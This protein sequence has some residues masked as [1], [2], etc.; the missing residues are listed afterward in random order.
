MREQSAR[1]GLC[2]RT[3]R[4]NGHDAVLGFEHIARARDDQRRVQVPHRQHRFQPAQHAVRTPVLGELHGRPLQLT[5]VFLELRLEALEERER[6]GGRAGEPRQHAVVV[7][8]PHLARGG[9]DDNVAE[10]DL[11]VTTEC[12]ARAAPNREDR[13]PVE[14]FHGRAARRAKRAWIYGAFL[15]KWRGEM[16]MRRR[17]ARLIGVAPEICTVLRWLSARPMALSRAPAH[18]K[19]IRSTPAMSIA[20]R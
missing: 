18:T 11:P 7:D 10:R 15:T 12:Y 2:V 19:S 9:F 8:A 13:C 1:G 3:A 20:M 17:S 14:G 4:P 6:V 16:P 5:L